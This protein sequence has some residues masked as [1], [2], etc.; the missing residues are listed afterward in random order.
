MATSPIAFGRFVLDPDRGTLHRDG[1]PV[2]VGQRGLVL[3]RVLLEAG[4]A[5][6]SKETLI[7]AAWPNTSI[8]DSN[9]TVQ[10]ATLRK[11]LGEQ[12]DGEEWIRTVP[13]VGYRLVP[14]RSSGRDA[15]STPKRVA[16]ESKPSVAVLPFRNMSSD[17]D[18]DYFAEGLSA[19]LITD[20]S[21]VPGL[22]VIARNSS[23]AY[24]GQPLDLRRFAEELGVRYV[25]DGSVRRAE[26]RVRINAELVDA[27]DNA[28][29]WADRF[30]RELADVF[31]LQDE[32]VGK[33]VGALSGVLPTGGHI[34]R[35]RATNL[36]A[37]DYFSRG[38]ALMFESLEG[39]RSARPLLERAIA[40]DPGF[41]EAHAC[42]AVNH[43]TAWA[44]WGGA[45]ED[46]KSVALSAA[47]KAVSLDPDN[48]DAHATL[49]YVEM[50]NG[51]A[52]LAGSE[53]QTALAIDPNSADAWLYSG[54]L[55]THQGEAATAIADIEK[56]FRLNPFPPGWYYWILGYAQ[57]AAGLY[58]DAVAALGHESTRRSGS[59]RLLAASLA[60]VGRID[61]ARFEAQ[62]FLSAN[63]DFSMRRWATAQPFR[64][65]ADREHF[66]D[67]YRKAGLPA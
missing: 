28:H 48:A 39:N 7:E 11:I 12:S 1:T 14:P 32:I 55:K 19:D 2:A 46:H 37:Y 58:G 4:G 18:Q 42:L 10:V 40:L 8:E 31:A 41:A 25:V 27:A 67:G 44:F 53:L 9:L 59:R 64:D 33:I 56:A 13:R 26:A 15:A 43:V 63:P 6:V 47:E 66:L 60:Q 17:P 21:K 16:A 62:Q 3:L 23:F 34:A 61:E 49:A 45:M 29:L 51:R 5:V 20:L 57:Y 65:D 30:D 24:K 50:Y 54:E 22:L 52:A 35:R 36:A 38:R